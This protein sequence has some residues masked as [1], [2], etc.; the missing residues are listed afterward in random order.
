MKAKLLSFAF[1]YFCESG[2]FNGLRPIQIKKSFPVS[3]CASNVTTR[4]LSPVSSRRG[5]RHGVNPA[6]GRHIIQ[7]SVFGKRLL[8]GLRFF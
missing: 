4:S 5:E 2:L 8:A 7:I 6:M 3:H 1:F